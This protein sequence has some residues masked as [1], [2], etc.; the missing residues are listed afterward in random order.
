LVHNGIVHPTT[1]PTTASYVDDSEKTFPKTIQGI[2]TLHI[3]N[4]SMGDQKHR[5]Q[6][7]VEKL[8]DY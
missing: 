2:L 3:P 4:Y 1:H 7:N 6:E 5:K 8:T